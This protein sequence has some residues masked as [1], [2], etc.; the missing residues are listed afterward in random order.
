MTISWVESLLCRWG[1]WAVR[2]ELDGIGFVSQAKIMRGW[3]GRGD[4]YGN[5]TPMGFCAEDVQA[6]DRAVMAL[7][8]GL[9]AVVVE[10]Y[11]R[12]GSVRKTAEACGFAPK[13]VTQYLDRAHCLIARHIEDERQAA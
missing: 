12:Q 6:C 9:R 3:S 8:S 4:S 5:G 1:R 11:Q 2:R 7:P 13:A 10:H